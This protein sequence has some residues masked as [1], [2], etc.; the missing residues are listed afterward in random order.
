MLPTGCIKEEKQTDIQN[1]DARVIQYKDEYTV[2]LTDQKLIENIKSYVS[3]S[4]K[5][6]EDLGESLF[7]VIHGDQTYIIHRR[8]I[9]VNSV[10]Y[11]YEEDLN[12]L[13]NQIENQFNQINQLTI[14]DMNASKIHIHIKDHEKTLQVT[15]E[16]YKF[17]MDELALST[18]LQDPPMIYGIRY[19]YLEMNLGNELVLTWI[20]PDIASIKL[21]DHIAGH[22]KLSSPTIWNTIQKQDPHAFERT[23]NFAVQSFKVRL[24]DA[25]FETDNQY[26]RLDELARILNQIDKEEPITPVKRD[27]PPAIVIQNASGEG[28]SYEIFPDDMVL[29]NYNGKAYKIDHFYEDMVSF[30]SVP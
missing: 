17:I 20:V 23:G 11:L 27:D 15:D 16:L 12:P 25:E 26:N 7:K 29:Y 22:I 19:P 18:T 1:S 10:K 5:T 9:E 28:P 4:R 24:K 2:P 30:F 6:H 14:K 8:G 21:R 3:K 13:F